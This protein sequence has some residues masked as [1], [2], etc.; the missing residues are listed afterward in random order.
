LEKGFEGVGKRRKKEKKKVFGR[1]GAA[2]GSEV[3]GERAGVEE[4]GKLC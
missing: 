3:F 1:E 2:S 4:Q